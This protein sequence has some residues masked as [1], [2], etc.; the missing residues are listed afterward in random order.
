MKT[1]TEFDPYLKKKK[2]PFNLPNICREL[3]H[4]LLSS[5]SV[6]APSTV[7]IRRPT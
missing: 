7:P 3:W 2:F 5:E 6:D 4:D 1:T